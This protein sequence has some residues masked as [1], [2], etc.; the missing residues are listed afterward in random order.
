MCEA[1]LPTP[2]PKRNTP[3][4]VAVLWQNFETTATQGNVYYRVTRDA[5][6]MYLLYSLIL[7]EYDEEYIPAYAVLVT[8]DRVPEIGRER[9]S[10][11]FSTFQA[12]ITTDGTKSYAILFYQTV[13]LTG[14]AEVGFNYGDG[15]NSFSV[16]SLLDGSS[17]GIQSRS[18]IM[19]FSAPGL[20]AYRIDSELVY[21]TVTMYQSSFV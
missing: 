17:D 19:S 4:T 13:N 10:S 1:C 2:F 8:W 5:E 11:R 12:V 18:N 20:Y 15:V 16:D 9:S 14:P 7:Q 6:Q 3:P 21:P